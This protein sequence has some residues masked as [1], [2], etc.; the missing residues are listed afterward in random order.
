[1]NSPAH[2][3]PP[4]RLLFDA[5]IPSRSHADAFAGM[6]RWGPYANSEVDLGEGSLLFVFPTSQRVAA[7]GLAKAVIDG[8]GTYKGFREMFDTP[9]EKRTAIDHVEVGVALDDPGAPAAYRTAIEGWA[10]TA[11]SHVPRLAVVVVPRSDRWETRSVYYESKAAFADLGI[12]SQ[13]VTAELLADGDRSKWAAADIALASFAKLGGV[14]WL[15]ESP[16]DESLVLGVGR[17]EIRRAGTVERVFGYAV[18][19]VSNG[20]YRQMWSVVPQSDESVYA[21][22]SVT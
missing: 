15:V 22:V 10:A 6:S 8:V 21:T 11:G 3:L 14:P 2:R 12:A 18:A 4:P 1:M 13:M 9:V 20:L 7:R 5:A 19:I 16:D 17:S